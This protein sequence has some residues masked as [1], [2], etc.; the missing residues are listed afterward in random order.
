MN[1]LFL[2]IK[3]SEEAKEFH[4]SEEYMQLIQ[5]TFDM[6]PRLKSSQDYVSTEDFAIT[7]KNDPQIRSIL[8]ELSR[9]KSQETGIPQENIA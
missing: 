4:L 7:A 5:D 9:L 8:N 6:I 2:L 1:G 3:S